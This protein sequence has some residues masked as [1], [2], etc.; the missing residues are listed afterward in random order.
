MNIQEIRNA[1]KEAERFLGRVNDL[2][3]SLRRG[4]EIMIMMVGSPETGA[5]R[6]SSM[7][8][9]RQLAKMRNV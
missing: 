6:R 2:W 9:T 8:L 4:D 5:V 3:D 1:E 7:D